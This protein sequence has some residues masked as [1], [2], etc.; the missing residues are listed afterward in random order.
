MDGQKK[1]GNE[2]VRG[3]RGPSQEGGDH[4]QRA[5]ALEIVLPL[6]P[7]TLARLHGRAPDWQI[8][9]APTAGTATLGTGM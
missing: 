2:P 7:S 5:P 1:D 6:C 9:C 3:R 4:S 8:T